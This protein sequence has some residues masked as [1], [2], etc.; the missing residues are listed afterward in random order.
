MRMGSSCDQEAQLL[1][2]GY[3]WLEERD[4]R[5]R[6]KLQMTPRFLF[7]IYYIKYTFLKIYLFQRGREKKRKRERERGERHRERERSQTPLSAE[8]NMGL[9][10]MALRSQLSQNQE[11][12]P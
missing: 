12:E 11:L 7:L 2:A 3:M 9:D 1:L 4:R 10:F 5:E 8:P 6:R